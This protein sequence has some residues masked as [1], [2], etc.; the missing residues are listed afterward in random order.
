MSSTKDKIILG[1]RDTLIRESDLKLLDPG[2][3]LNDN[4]LSFWF[5]YLQDRLVPTNSKSYCCV[6]PEMTQ[7]IKSAHQY[8]EMYNELERI[9]NDEFYN[10]DVLFVPINDCDFTTH[11]GYH[12]SL[13]VFYKN[14]T[15]SNRAE[16]Y[17]SISSSNIKIASNSN[18]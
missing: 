2:E 1:F 12:W 8:E 10:K 18:Y 3:W 9:L 4:I 17:D 15:P 5:A 11:G 16:H 13:L 14:S 7:F 6:C